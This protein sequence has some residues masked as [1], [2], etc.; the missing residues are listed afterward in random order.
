M[1]FP[2][3]KMVGSNG[4]FSYLGQQKASEELA[5]DKGHQWWMTAEGA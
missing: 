5:E 4:A 1:K 2:V 3:A